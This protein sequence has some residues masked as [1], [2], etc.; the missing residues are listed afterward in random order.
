MHIPGFKSK[1]SLT[2]KLRPEFNKQVNQ[3]NNVL[4]LPQHLSDVTQEDI[5]KI[6][7]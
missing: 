5:I 2:Q 4:K 6:L 1:S 7:R 3:S